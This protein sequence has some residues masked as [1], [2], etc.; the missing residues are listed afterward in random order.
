MSKLSSNTKPLHGPGGPIEDFNF[1][2]VMFSRAGAMTFARG[3]LKKAKSDGC[4]K[5]GLRDCGDY[6]RFSIC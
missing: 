3:Q 1:E 5:V 4:K 2:P 6:W